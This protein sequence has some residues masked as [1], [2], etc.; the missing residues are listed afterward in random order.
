MRSRKF[1]GHPKAV[2]RVFELWW[3]GTASGATGNLNLV[4]PGTPAGGSSSSRRRSF[5]IEIWAGKVVIVIVPIRT[6]LVDILA[7]VEQPMSIRRGGRHRL[8]SVTPAGMII[9]AVGNGFVT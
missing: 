6:P 2:I 5:G 7:K 1:A 9:C 8:G 4:S 3:Y